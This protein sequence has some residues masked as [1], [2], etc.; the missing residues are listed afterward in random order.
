M[1]D[2]YVTVN[3]NVATEPMLRIGKNSGRP[4]LTFRLAQNIQRVDRA[5]GEIKDAATNYMSV[6][7]FG[8]LATNLGCSLAKGMP[9]IVHG[10]LRISDWENEERKGT[11]V[12][13]HAT[14][15]GPDLRFGQA[16]FSRVSHGSRARSG[17]GELP[18]ESGADELEQAAGGAPD[19][20]PMADTS[21]VPSSST[22]G[23]S[24]AAGVPA[25]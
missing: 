17:D 4:F 23:H 9:I 20:A 11:S 14:S 2:S 18:A 21:A 22:L 16:V 5:T 25:A 13:I 3:G 7:A 6:S 19:A 12:D 8:A 24:V 10:R 1:N 15:V